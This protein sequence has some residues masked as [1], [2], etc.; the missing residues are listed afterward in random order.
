[1]AKKK[2]H[3]LETEKKLLF[4]HNTNYCFKKY[5]HNV[6]T[7]PSHEEGEDKESTNDVTTT[8]DTKK[9]TLILCRR[10]VPPRDQ[11]FTENR[12][13]ATS[14]KHKCAFCGSI[15]SVQISTYAQ[16][17]DFANEIQ[18]SFFL[19]PPYSFKTRFTVEQKI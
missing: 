3:I 8:F 11:L 7:K 17:T 9:S 1:M 4:F 13:N 12:Q 2:F 19:M 18:P 15:R 16:N 10:S 5:T 14:Q 6:Y